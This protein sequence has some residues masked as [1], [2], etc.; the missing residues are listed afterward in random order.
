MRIT[1]LIWRIV[2]K[3]I[4]LLPLIVLLA[5]VSISSCAPSTGMT[6]DGTSWELASL[7]G[8][9]LVDGSRITLSF[10][11]GEIS[12]NAGCNSYFGEYTLSVGGLQVGAVSITEM[13]CLS[14]EG[15]MEQ[16]TTY[17]H[18]LGSVVKAVREGSQLKLQDASGQDILV[19][20][21]V[22]E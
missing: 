7:A 14:P 5:L 17:A 1:D 9:P 19:F 3:R 21:A 4:R 15:V 11:D 6:L 20:S 18:Y 8:M 13:A 16:E 12:G 2:M 10:E 22:N